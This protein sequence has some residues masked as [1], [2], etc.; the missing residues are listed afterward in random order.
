MS[1]HDP[2][3]FVMNL[4]TPTKLIVLKPKVSNLALPGQEDGQVSMEPKSMEIL[5]IN[6]VRGIRSLIARGILVEIP[7]LPI[8]DQL[9]FYALEQQGL[10]V[11]EPVA[12]SQ[13]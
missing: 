2:N 6:D 8:T 1:S 10:A 5:S 13:A 11:R 12:E 3:K 4:K 7:S 9:L